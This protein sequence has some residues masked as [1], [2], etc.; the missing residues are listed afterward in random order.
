MTA[1]HSGHGRERFK[2]LIAALQNESDVA[3]RCPDCDVHYLEEQW[4]GVWECPECGRVE[5][6]RTAV[7]PDCPYCG[8]PAL[9]IHWEAE[10]V[11]CDACGVVDKEDLRALLDR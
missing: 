11:E 1:G 8:Q 2:A 9:V 4:P 10:H 5:N 6:P 3:V 7:D